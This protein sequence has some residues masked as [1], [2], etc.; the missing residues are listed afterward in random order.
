MDF[1]HKMLTQA[2]PD[3]KT[4]KAINTI[5]TYFGMRR[6]ELLITTG[7]SETEIT[8][9][10]VWK[11]FRHIT[12]SVTLEQRK[13]SSWVAVNREEDTSLF[14]EYLGLGMRGKTWYGSPDGRLRGN[15]SEFT[16]AHISAEPEEESDAEES[17]AATSQLEMKKKIKKMSQT[18]GTAVLASFTEHNLH[19]DENPLVPCILMDCCHVQ[20]VMY[21]CLNDVLL[22]TDKVVMRDDQGKAYKYAVLFLWLFIN[23]RYVT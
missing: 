4:T 8:R 10:Y 12:E 14:S 5:L 15:N 19:S 2:S 1:D 23:H 16:P 11:I 18:I 21:D 9:E 22:M 7:L 20:V 13:H 17:D 6:R 3:P